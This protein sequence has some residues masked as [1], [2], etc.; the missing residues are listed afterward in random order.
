MGGHVEALAPWSMA[1]IEPVGLRV[2]DREMSETCLVAMRSRRSPLTSHGT[3]HTARTSTDAHGRTYMDAH[4][5]RAYGTLKYGHAER[6]H[7]RVAPDPAETARHAGRHRESPTTDRRWI[8]WSRPDGV[9]VCSVQATAVR[10]ES[11]I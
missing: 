9:F 2:A 4:G 6:T 3:H 8:S 11:G 7:A 10:L 5:P 1:Q